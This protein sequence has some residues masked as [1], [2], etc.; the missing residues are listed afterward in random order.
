MEAIETRHG[1]TVVIE[2]RGRLDS[3]TARS[4]EEKLL[5]AIAP[6][7]PVMVVDCSQLDYVSSAGLRVLLM[8]AKRVKAAKG[9]LALCGLKPHVQEVF[10]VSGFSSIF[11]I[12]PN[13]AAALAAF[14]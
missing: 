5:G 13:R 12:H 4:F 9:R 8:A 10:D 2:A 6:A 14:P 3:N 1:G 7:D 11:V